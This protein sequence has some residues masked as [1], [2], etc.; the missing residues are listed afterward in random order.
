MI[1][2]R[3]I[4][5][6]TK[7]S[8][9]SNVLVFCILKHMYKIFT[10]KILFMYKIKIIRVFAYR[11]I[12]SPPKPLILK[13]NAKKHIS[14]VTKEEYSSGYKNITEHAKENSENINYDQ[15]LGSP[16]TR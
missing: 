16:T 13:Q 1:E 12:P 15:N 14:F 4:T 2:N 5:N 8:T 9:K 11:S 7:Q 3:L 10:N 6:T